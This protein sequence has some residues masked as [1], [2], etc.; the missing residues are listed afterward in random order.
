MEKYLQF[1][2][3]V[4][5]ELL[6]RAAKLSS[7]QL[8]D[9][10]SGL[11]LLGDGCLDSRILPVHDSM[12]V[13]GTAC[14]VETEE[15][16]NFPIHV[17]IYQGKPGYVLM[18]AGGGYDKR[19]Y[20]GDLMAGAAHAVG[21]SGVVVD[22]YVR[23]KTGLSELGLP[24]FARGYMQ[25]SPVKLNPGRINWPVSCGGARVNPGDL[26]FGDYDGVTVVPRERLEEVLERAEKKSAYEVKRRMVIEEYRTNREKGLPLPVL[27]P[28]WVL[29]MLNKK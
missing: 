14:T 16:D 7:A 18:V 8:C 17:A 6:E 12:K 5:N 26:V 10:M 21:L 15:G 22:G 24:I 4:P 29:E 20:M 25:R 19:A 27:A 23:D 2:D 9:G 28:D 11:G 13:V 1:P 3:P